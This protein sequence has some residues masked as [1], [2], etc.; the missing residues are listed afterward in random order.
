[1]VNKII[2]T[3]F[4][5]GKKNFAFV[6]EEILFNYQARANSTTDRIKNLKLDKFKFIVFKHK[7]LYKECFEELIEYLLRRIKNEQSHNQKIKST[8][9]YKLGQTLLKPLRFL[10]NR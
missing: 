1:M 10:K 8:E 3:S 2:I 4:D 9:D 7:E 5:I 6:I